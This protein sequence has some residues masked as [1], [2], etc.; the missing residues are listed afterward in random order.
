MAAPTAGMHFTPE[1]LLDLRAQGVQIS[2]VTLRIGLD[3]FKPISAKEIAE[4]PMHSEWAELGANTAR[5]INETKLAG[6]RVVAVGTTAVRTLET[7]AWR[8]NP[9]DCDSSVCA[10]NTVNAFEGPTRL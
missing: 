10:W 5:Q 7:A 4:H 8:A 1:L 9:D 2:Y 3:T 6:G